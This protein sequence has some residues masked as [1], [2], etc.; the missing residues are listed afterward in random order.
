MP[1]LNKA[2]PGRSILYGFFSHFKEEN[3][4]RN[5]LSYKTSCFKVKKYF[6]I[7]HPEMSLSNLGHVPIL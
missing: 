3:L 4:T 7:R 2:E 5:Y 6:V 1:Y